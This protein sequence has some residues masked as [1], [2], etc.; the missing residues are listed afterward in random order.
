MVVTYIAAGGGKSVHFI[1]ILTTQN[2]CTMGKFVIKPN[3]KGQ[4]Y[5]C[6]KADNGLNILTS[7]GYNSKS[8][9]ANG[10][11]SI[12]NNAKDDSKYDRKESANGKYYFNLRA[13]NGHIIGTSEMYEN[14]TG[15]DKGIESVKSNA[16]GAKVE[17]E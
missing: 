10:I 15:R 7:E 2:I 1:C 4:V 14:A 11:D 5:F 12:K 9:C 16:P 6:L 13:A 17:E 3:A 8:A